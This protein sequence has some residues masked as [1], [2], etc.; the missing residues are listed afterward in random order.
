MLDGDANL[1]SV[2]TPIAHPAVA[3]FVIGHWIRRIHGSFVNYPD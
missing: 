2:P 1:V 3:G